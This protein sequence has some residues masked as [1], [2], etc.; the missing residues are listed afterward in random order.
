MPK[1]IL[2]Q[3][4]FALLLVSSLGAQAAKPTDWT[5]AELALAAPFCIDT[6]GWKYGDATSKPSPRAGYW[7]GLMGTD[8]WHMHHYCVA[9]INL[10]RVNR[11]PLSNRNYQYGEVIA[12]LQYVTRNSRPDFIML[13]EVY[14][15]IGEVELLRNNPA[16][17]AE[18]FDRAR[19]LKPDFAPAYTHW[20]RAQAK[21]G[22]RNE[23]LALLR[24]GLGHAPD[25]VPMRNLFK[26][27]GGN[28]STLPAAL[29]KPTGDAPAAAA[30]P[31][32]AS[33]PAPAASGS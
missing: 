32:A 21:S 7:V 24:E 31:G 23:A 25:S 3:G 26:E 16:A 5:E 12:D 6:M 29:A 18:A 9:M 33:S 1:S 14:A 13:P 27:L 15:R 4:L 8:F 19:K 28:P 30:K 20:A 17:A 11:F 2:P 22:K 10:R